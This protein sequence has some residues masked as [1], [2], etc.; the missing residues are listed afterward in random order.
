MMVSANKKKERNCICN[1]QEKRFWGHGCLGFR[2]NWLGVMLWICRNR[3]QISD[4]FRCHVYV[5]TRH[6]DG[7][8]FANVVQ[9]LEIIVFCDFNS[10]IDYYILLL[11]RGL[12][13][14]INLLLDF[15][16]N[17]SLNCSSDSFAF[18]ITCFYLLDF[19]I[20]VL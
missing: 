13:L 11:V 10:W 4:T 20:L 19:K 16:E 3:V 9:E 2:Y 15:I 8:G 12:Q 6:N 1:C 17:K 5:G 14:I 7:W 18:Y